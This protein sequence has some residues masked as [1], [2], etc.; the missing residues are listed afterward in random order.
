M[1]KRLETVLS[2]NLFCVPVDLAGIE[3][4]L[5]ECS[6]VTPRVS[7]MGTRYFRARLAGDREERWVIYEMWIRGLPAESGCFR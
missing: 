5:L 4:A 1:L 6:F 7:E 2:G 3:N